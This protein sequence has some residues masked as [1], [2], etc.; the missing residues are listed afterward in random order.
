MT[1]PWLNCEQIRQDYPDTA[2]TEQVLQSIGVAAIGVESTGGGGQGAGCL[3][4]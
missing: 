1:P 3:S 2:I 4:R